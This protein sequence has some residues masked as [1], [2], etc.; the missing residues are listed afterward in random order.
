[1]AAPH[2]MQAKQSLDGREIADS[3]LP[4]VLSLGLKGTWRCGPVEK[5]TTGPSRKDHRAT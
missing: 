3:E 5:V 4:V 2:G 1:M